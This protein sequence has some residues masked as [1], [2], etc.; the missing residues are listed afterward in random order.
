MFKDWVSLTPKL[1]K[2]GTVFYTDETKG[3]YE[4]TVSMTGT[5]RLINTLQQWTAD[6]I[7]A[8]HKRIRPM[9]H[10]FANCTPVKI[11]DQKC[12]IKN[13]SA[14]LFEADLVNSVVKIASIA[15]KESEK[16]ISVT[17]ADKEKRV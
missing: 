6:Y 4:N 10:I 8:L 17:N 1:L 16:S 7:N 12:L 3:K 14:N 5:I 15:F 2:D 9:E 13:E 11:I